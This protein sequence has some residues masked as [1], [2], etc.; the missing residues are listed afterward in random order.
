MF[1]KASKGTAESGRDELTLLYAAGYDG[2]AAWNVLSAATKKGPKRADVDALFTTLKSNHPDGVNHHR[3][4]VLVF[5]A[6]W[7]TG[8]LDPEQPETC[9][10]L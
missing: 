1:G 4:G 3:T 5:V 8:G 10:S 6:N 7:G 2:R 9:P